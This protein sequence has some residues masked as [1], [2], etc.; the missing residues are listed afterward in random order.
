MLYAGGFASLLLH[1]FWARTRSTQSNPSAPKTARQQ[2]EAVLLGVVVIGLLGTILISAFGWLE[3]RF[4]GWKE[5][6]TP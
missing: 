2:W 3:K 6:N 1:S 5:S 4:A